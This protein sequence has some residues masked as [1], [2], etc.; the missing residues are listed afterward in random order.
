MVCQPSLPFAVLAFRQIIV[1]TEEGI[2]FLYHRQ[3]GDYPWSVYP[4]GKYQLR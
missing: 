2:H 3:F 1:K 4:Y